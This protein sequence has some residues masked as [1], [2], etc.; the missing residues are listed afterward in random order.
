MQISSQQ[1]SYFQNLIEVDS[2]EMSFHRAISSTLVFGQLLGLMPL[3]GI[4]YRNETK[5]K[6]KWKSFRFFYFILI[7]IGSIISLISISWWILKHKELT[8][9]SF[10][11]FMVYLCNVTTLILFLKLQTKWPSL[12]KY[13]IA[14]DKS[15]PALERFN[16][17][18]NQMLFVGVASSVS[19][20]KCN[21]KFRQL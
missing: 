14:V 17:V 16:Y 8:L 3:S 21:I 5:L 4:C 1:E 2:N 13:W 19:E 10:I 6:F 18:P 7:T 9:R 20:H 12:V 11:V 15:L